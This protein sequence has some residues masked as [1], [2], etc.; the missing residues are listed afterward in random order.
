M[1]IRRMIPMGAVQRRC[2]ICDYPINAK[3]EALTA[4][5]VDC[6]VKLTTASSRSAQSEQD[7][8]QAPCTA[9]LP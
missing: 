7:C 5:E 2:V 4:H 1:S 8:E 6:L 3:G 9:F